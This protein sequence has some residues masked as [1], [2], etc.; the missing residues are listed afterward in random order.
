MQGEVVTDLWDVSESRQVSSELNV[1]RL[2]LHGTDLCR[3]KSL[4]RTAYTDSVEQVNRT[5]LFSILLKL[6]K[7]FSVGKTIRHG[8]TIPF[9]FSDISQNEAECPV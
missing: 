5:G 4:K 6:V 2:L 1:K 8:D 9:E 7:H 3:S